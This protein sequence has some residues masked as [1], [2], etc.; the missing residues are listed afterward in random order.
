VSRPRRSRRSR[1][2]FNGVRLNFTGLS[3]GAPDCPV[4]QRSTVQRSTTKSAGDTWPAQRSEGGTGL[5]GVHQTVS[6]APTDAEVQ[7]SSAP[8]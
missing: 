8:N 7:Q 4:S 3:D 2:K 1:E 5:S 6:G